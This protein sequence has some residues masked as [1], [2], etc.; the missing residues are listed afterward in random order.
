[1]VSGAGAA[2][3]SQARPKNHHEAAVRRAAPS[4][5]RTVD[6]VGVEPTPLGLK[7]RLAPTRPG[8]PP[9]VHWIKLGR[10]RSPW[11]NPPLAALADR[12]SDAPATRPRGPGRRGL[13]VEPRRPGPCGP[14]PAWADLAASRRR[15]F[16]LEQYARRRC[17]FHEQAR[18][19]RAVKFFAGKS[20][21]F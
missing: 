9:H 11:P 1:M 15:E 5:A 14:S 10:L 3:P 19:L 8:P 17:G 12:V 21:E 4:S 20:F 7:T 2:A 13:N 18:D 16:P 6:L